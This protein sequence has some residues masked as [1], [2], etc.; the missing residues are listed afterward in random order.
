MSIKSLDVEDTIRFMGKEWRIKKISFGFTPD[1]VIIEA[2]PKVEP[3]PTLEL[4][5][6][7]CIDR[8]LEGCFYGTCLCVF[9]RGGPWQS[10]VRYAT[11][12]GVKHEDYLANV[13]EVRRDGKLIWERKKK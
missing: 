6:W 10:Y 2:E 5:D 3:V 9:E 8:N 1:D 7:I 4:G 13:T 12:G 11:P